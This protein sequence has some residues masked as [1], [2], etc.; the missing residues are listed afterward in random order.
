MASLSCISCSIFLVNFGHSHNQS[1]LRLIFQGIK[2]NKMWKSTPFFNSDTQ[3]IFVFFCLQA[4]PFTKC[5][6]NFQTRNIRWKFYNWNPRK[7][8]KF[9]LFFWKKTDHP[10]GF[11]SKLLK[12]LKMT[13]NGLKCKWNWSEMNLKLIWNGP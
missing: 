4:F 9:Q 1:N 8:T 11:E 10:N 7:L 3:G 13:Q 12:N 5:A 2:V 6:S